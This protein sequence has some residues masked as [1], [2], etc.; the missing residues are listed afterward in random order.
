MLQDKYDSVRTLLVSHN[1]ALGFDF[2]KPDEKPIG[3]VDPDGFTTCIKAAGGTSEDRLKKFSYEDILEC[4]PE[5]NG[6]R[7]KALAKEIAQIF[8]GKDE[9]SVPQSGNHSP[10]PVSAKKA[11]RMS[12]KELVEHFDPE[13]PTNP[14]GKRLTEISRREPFIVYETGRIVDVDTTTKLLLELKSGFPEGRK[15]VTVGDQI[16]P[17]YAIGYLPEH[18][19]DENPIYA[20]RPLRPDGTCDQLNRSWDGVELEVRQFIRVG[21]D[22]S[23]L[24]VSRDK[25]HDYLDW[26]LKIDSMT[27]LRNRYPEVSIEFDRLKKE[28]NLPA[29]Q[30]ELGQPV[31]VEEGHPARPFDDGKKVQWVEHLTPEGYKYRESMSQFSRRMANGPTRKSGGTMSGDIAQKASSNPWDNT[32]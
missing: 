26:S 22:L 24:S 32:K 20:G 28:G 27:Y 3:F 11:D 13:E 5:H 16:K 6:V 18:Y 21:I 9:D 29:L 31:A 12:P 2:E 8:R 15:T 7:P 30:I 25:A 19:V 14:V 10:R 17:V 1:E 4:L 23:Q